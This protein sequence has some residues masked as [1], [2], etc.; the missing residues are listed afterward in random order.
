MDRRSSRRSSTLPVE[1]MQPRVLRTISRLLQDESGQDLI[2]YGLLFGI[3]S[4]GLIVTMPFIRTGLER[5]FNYWGDNR[6]NLWV[7][8]DPTP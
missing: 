3:V 8:A 1:A 2:E 6:N 5:S 7:P 4:A